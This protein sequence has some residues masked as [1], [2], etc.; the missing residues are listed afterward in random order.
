MQPTPPA[1]RAAYYERYFPLHDV[2]RLL[3]HGRGT[4]ELRL[5]ELALTDPRGAMRR[6]VSY[7]DPA[8]LRRALA[9][10]ARL[11]VGAVYAA[12]AAE[13]KQAGLGRMQ[14]LRR[15]LV[16]DLDIGDFGLERRCAC[17][18]KDY[19]ARCWP[20]LRGS[21]AVLELLLGPLGLGLAERYWFFSGRRGLHCWVRD[22]ALAAARPEE[23]EL[24]LAQLKP[25]ALAADSPLQKALLSLGASLASQLRETHGQLSDEAA[26]ALVWPRPDEPVTRDPRHLLKAPFS[27]HPATGAVCLYLEDPVAF[28]PPAC[29]GADLRAELVVCRGSPSRKVF[30]AAARALRKRLS[31][32]PL[33]L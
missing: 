18:D 3:G 29:G 19:C 8:A 15:D 1:V 24:L 4:Q 27:L 6:H 11:D 32:E 33:L 28:V 14:P 10:A 7:G 31:R 22:A 12:A 17:A 25:G 23:R 5:R 20:L 13:R 2:L 9:S 26:L 30:L 21:A 16:F